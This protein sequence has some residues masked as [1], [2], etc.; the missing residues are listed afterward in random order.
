MKELIWR[1]VKAVRLEHL[2]ETTKSNI[3]HTITNNYQTWKSERR[4]LEEV[5]HQID[6][7][8][9][10]Y[11]PIY[12]PQ[13]KIETANEL[14]MPG[15]FGSKLKMTNVYAHREG[16][17]SLMMKY[18]MSN[19]YDFFDGIAFDPI[20]EDHMLALKT[21]LLWMFDVMDLESSFTPFCRDVVHYGWGV[22]SYEW[23]REVHPRWKRQSVVDPVT[24]ERYVVDFEAQEIV[25]DAPKFTPLNVY[26]TVLDPTAADVR[27][28]TLIYKKAVTTHELM[29][30]SS[31]T[32]D[33]KDVE[34]A[35]RFG[36]N[37]DSNIET[38]REH[39]RGNDT[40]T[41]AQSYGDKRE[42]LECWG[43]ISDG[44]TLY[45]NY[46]AEVM[47]GKLIRFEPNPYNMP[48]KPFV[49]ARYTAETGRIYGSSPLATITGLQ[50]G[51]DTIFNQFVDFWTMENQRPILAQANTIIRTAKDNT[52]QLP[53][54]HNR[55]VWMVRDVNGIKRLDWSAG[56]RT[57]DPTPMLNLLEMQME[58]ATG[59]NFLMSGGAPQ[60]Y[61]KTGVAMTAADAGNSKMNMYA[62]NIE[63]EAIIPILEM[64]VDLLRQMDVAPRTFKRKDTPGQEEIIFDPAMLA[65]NIRFSLRGASYNMTKQMQLQSFQSFLQWAQGNPVTMQLINWVKAIKMFGEALGLRN[66]S[67]LITPEGA[68][69]LQSMNQQ[70]SFTQKVANLLFGRQSGTPPAP[71]EANLG[72][73]LTL[74]SAPAFGGTNPETGSVSPFDVVNR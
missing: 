69:M 14:Q 4:G 68:Q 40:F 30:N 47:N 26:Y 71:Q 3:I 17:V 34:A 35:P 55:S 13:A 73:Q 12:T 44:R 1:P 50:A 60:Q 64:T 21:Y 22:S 53:P 29:A 15:G 48:Y 54:L 8:V 38:R 11:D 23:I 36:G 66:A 27:S 51:Y 62:K 10:Q 65:N 16:I 5:W 37:A 70:P 18:L 7:H 72:N 59:D 67:D 61:L 9:N 39:A 52:N 46:V 58:K 41:H 63:K 28:A 42:V 32:L 25:Y 74:P 24:G 19:D 33:W 45:K 20:D 31:Y 2:D 49:V 6:R 57:P 43:D 56:A